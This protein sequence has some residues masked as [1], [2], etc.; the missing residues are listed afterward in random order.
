M[1]KLTG[2]KPGEYDG[3]CL[4]PSQIPPADL[5]DVMWRMVKEAGVWYQK[6]LGG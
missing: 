3:L 5:D 1:F 2:T 6:E 4:N